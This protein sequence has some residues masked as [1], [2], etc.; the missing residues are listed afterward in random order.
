MDYHQVVE[1]KKRKYGVSCFHRWGKEG[2]NPV[3]IAQ[4]EHRVVILKK[5]K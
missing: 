5:R 4:G 1:K 2:G 3:L